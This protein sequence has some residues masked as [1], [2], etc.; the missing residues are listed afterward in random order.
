MAQK[1]KKTTIRDVARQAGISYQ[2]VSRVLNGNNNVAEE[3]RK[4]VLLA[5]QELDF[6]PN[7]VAQ[8]LNTNRS[9][10]LELIIVDIMQGGHFADSIRSMALAARDAGYNLL[11]TMTSSDELGM[12]LDNAAA[13]L[14]DGVVMYAPS[15]RISDEKLLELCNGLPLVRRDYV[16]NSR[17]AWVGF[18]QVYATRMAVEYFIE[19]G[20]RQIAAI[21]PSTNLINGQLRYTT[22]KETLRQHGLEPGPVHEAHYTFRSGYEAMEHILATHQPFTA[23]LVGSDTMALGAMHA[24][25]EHG[26]HIPNDVSVLSFDNAELASFTEPP[27]TT[28]N[29]A[30]REQDS[31]AIKYLVEILNNSEMK[32]HQRILLPDL[33]V[34]KSTRKLAIDTAYVQ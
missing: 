34:R 24:L 18:D 16:P 31:M 11:V 20:H 5:M 1:K 6:V 33:V 10:I 26:L 21:P 9:Q 29:F 17:L 30:F 15:L 25:H 12:A 7:K 2:T 3:T 19:L 27:L 23:V 4:R 13:R 22:W 8:M 28:I 32:L 14:V